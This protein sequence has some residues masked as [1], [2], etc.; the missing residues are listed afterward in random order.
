MRDCEEGNGADNLN[1]KGRVRVMRTTQTGLAR[2]L[3]PALLG[4]TLVMLLTGIVAVAS[5]RG[6]QEVVY[7]FAPTVLTDEAPFAGVPSPRNEDVLTPTNCRY[8][9][10]FVPDFSASLDWIST[11]D[12]GWFVDFS[13]R[14]PQKEVDSAHFMPVVRLKQDKEN[15]T[16]L[17]TYTF[18]PPLVYKQNNGQPGL[19]QLVVDNPGELWIIGNEPDVDNDS[20]DNT[21]PDVYARAYHEAYHYI[22][23]IDPTARVANAGLS[24]ITPGRLQYLTIVWDTY[25]SLYGEEMPVDVWNMH[26]YILEERNPNNPNQYGDGKIALGTDPNIARLSAIADTSLCPDPSTPL[27]DPRPDVNCRSEH[28]SLRVFQ[29]QVY[30]M[31]NWMKARGQQNKPFIISEFGL[32]YPYLGGQPDGTCEFL[33]DEFQRCFNPQRVTEYLNGTVNFMETATDPALGYPA[34]GNRLV[35][36]WLWYSIVTEEFWSG[37]SSNLIVRNYEAFAPGAIAALTPIGQAFR[38]QATSR[39]IAS[40]LAGG[41]A[42][43]VSTYADQPGGRGLAEI[44]ATYRNDGLRS[45]VEPFTV[46]FYKNAALTQVIGSVRVNPANVGAIVGCSWDGRNSHRV[47][48]MWDDLPVGTHDYWAVI[49]SGNEVNESNNGDN[50]TTKGTVTV[51]PR[52]AFIPV[53]NGA[54]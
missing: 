5:A 18:T 27:I 41:E 53:V 25:K 29:E 38:Q 4:A 20:Q 45:V 42:L 33:Q 28:D 14:A 34:D 51:S 11:L 50:I 44:T 10:G 23:A 2:K 1:K 49:D 21:M 40:N 19:G 15:G 13:A 46:T 16:R 12:A 17:P 36:Q 43:D 39:P 7:D 9:V 54:P 52:Y 35:Q 6:Q 8:G 22:K 26:L 31:R 24:M 37:G 32:L 47:E 30:A 3:A 48:I